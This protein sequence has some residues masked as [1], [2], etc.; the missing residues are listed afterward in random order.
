MDVLAETISIESIDP[1]STWFLPPP[2][3][4]VPVASVAP[5]VPVVPVAPVAP[6][7][8]VA[9]VAPVVPTV[10]VVPVVPVPVAPVVPVPVVPDRLAFY[11][12]YP[13]PDYSGMPR[14]LPT[15]DG[16]LRVRN[17]EGRHQCRIISKLKNK[18]SGYELWHNKI[19]KW[20]RRKQSITNLVME[21]IRQM[22]PNMMEED[23]KK[24][25]KEFLLANGKNLEF[26]QNFYNKLISPQND[27]ELSNEEDQNEFFE[28]Y[29]TSKYLLTP[30]SQ[31]IECN[32]RSHVFKKIKSLHSNR[33]ILAYKYYKKEGFENYT[34]YL[35]EYLKDMFPENIFFDKED[36]KN[37][38]EEQSSGYYKDFFPDM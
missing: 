25:F 8:P 2:V 31:G 18:A 7:V 29:Y 1:T 20:I 10:P 24:I 33:C 13:M 14:C 34:D 6:V 30:K 38:L 4:P 16:R 22:F 9:P 17:P 37:I 27:I 26:K 3:V 36:E 28:K 5:T 32:G 12:E 19:K 21:N 35:Y 15:A 23:H 11:D